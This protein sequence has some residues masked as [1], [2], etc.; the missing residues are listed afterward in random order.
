M[1]DTE[2]RV[3]STGVL[4]RMTKKIEEIE[5]KTKSITDVGNEKEIIPAIED[6]VIVSIEIQLETVLKKAL[7]QLNGVL[8]ISHLK[9]R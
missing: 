6:V 4:D 3:L 1:V 2:G 8:P 7:N 9:Q 5:K